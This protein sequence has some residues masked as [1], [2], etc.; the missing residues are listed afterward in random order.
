MKQEF[1]QFAPLFA[2]LAPE[3]QN[4]LDERF[5]QAKAASGDVLFQVGDTAD[6]LFL[7][8]KGF[9]RLFTAG[10]SNLA[11]L[12]PGSVLGEDSLYRSLPYDVSAH[13]AS[14]LEYWKLSDK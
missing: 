13:A 9:V 10:G 5:V 1:I 4:I 6:G 12:G 11:T 14:E 7:L 8:G 3:E 2:G